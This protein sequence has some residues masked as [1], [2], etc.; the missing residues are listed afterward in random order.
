MI[1]IS[2]M[3]KADVLKRLY[4][5]AKPQG[6]GFLEYTPPPMLLAKAQ[7]MLDDGQTYFDYVRG[8]VLKVDLKGD[9][10]SPTLYDRDNGM[11]AAAAA[12]GV[13]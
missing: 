6:M 11:G 13:E 4:D 10:F 1:D 9:E 5:S 3:K 12:L 8:R 2:K 7:S